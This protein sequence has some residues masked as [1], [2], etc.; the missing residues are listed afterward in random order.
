MS[1]RC[2]VLLSVLIVLSSSASASAQ[3][4]VE[5]HARHLDTLAVFQDLCS[6]A[7]PWL[8]KKPT[9][10]F[11]AEYKLGRERRTHAVHVV[12]IDSR[13]AGLVYEASSQLL[14]PVQRGAYPVFDG[15]FAVRLRGE[16]LLG[17]E[18]D[19]DAAESVR[20]QWAAGNAAIRIYFVLE[21]FRDPFAPFC[22]PE[23]AT[24]EVRGVLVGA[25][26]IEAGGQGRLAPPGVEKS[27]GTV[28][29]KEG[30]RLLAMLGLDGPTSTALPHRTWVGNA[31]SVKSKIPEP[32]MADYRQRVEM[33]MTPCHLSSLASGGPRAGSMV[34]VTH[35]EKAGVR[36]HIPV[37][38]TGFPAFGQCAV[39][40]LTRMKFDPADL[41]ASAKFVLYF[42]PN[43]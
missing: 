40:V 13:T 7:P 11:F 25:H 24:I 29:G 37:E 5:V 12:D 19:Q 3:A 34:V 9:D 28:R 32:R 4:P 33:L 22:R 2:T 30:R 17:F 10:P 14:T 21:A 15:S 31:T 43:E 27:L 1:T 26:L 35:F 16:P 42:E 20:V 23:G 6:Y 41:G 38:V 8:D 39:K 36:A 18:L